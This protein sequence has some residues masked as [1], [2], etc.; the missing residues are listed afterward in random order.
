M[1]NYVSDF[2]SLLDFLLSLPPSLS[3]SSLIFLSL[4]FLF[5]FCS[6]FSSFVVSLVLHFCLSFAYIPYLLPSFLVRF[7]HTS[8]FQVEDPPSSS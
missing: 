6:L 5:V 2:P 7:F 3:V 4:P 1:L 8:S